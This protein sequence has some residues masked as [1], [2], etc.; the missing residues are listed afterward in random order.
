[1]L[2]VCTIYAIVLLVVTSIFNKQKAVLYELY[3]KRLSLRTEFSA[4]TRQQPLTNQYD[5]KYWIITPT[6]A[7]PWLITVSIHIL[8]Q[9][10]LLKYDYIIIINYYYYPVRSDNALSF[11]ATFTIDYRHCWLRKT[12]F[13]K[14]TLLIRS[15]ICILVYLFSVASERT[16]DA[17]EMPLQFGNRN[18]KT[19][20]FLRIKVSLGCSLLT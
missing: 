10:N 20:I 19:M 17:H 7:G 13:I 4:S 8:K 2:I 6:N 5:W 14:C 18:K 11:F 16:L 3:F 15:H 1:M 9:V 12:R